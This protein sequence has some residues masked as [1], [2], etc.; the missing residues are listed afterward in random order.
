MC[1]QYSN[2]PMSG[3]RKRGEVVKTVDVLKGLYSLRGRWTDLAASGLSI[4]FLFDKLPLSVGK[5]LERNARLYADSTAIIFENT[6]YTYEELNSMVNRMANFF[7]A[8]GIR[9][10][11]TAIVFLENRPESLMVTAALA[12]LG[13]AASL[14]HP[15]QRGAVLLHS[16][17]LKSSRFF[18]VGE[19]LIDAFEEV[20]PELP[21][22][23][24]LV[25]GLAD[26]GTFDFPD[27]YIDLQRQLSGAGT[28]NPPETGD[29]R[30]GDHL[31]YIFTSGTTGQPK[32]AIQTHK[33][34]LRCM[35]WFGR[36]NLS[37]K[38]DDVLYAP[39]PFFHANVFLIAWPAV[40]TY[41]ATLVMRRKFSVS[42]FWSD[43]RKYNAT[44]FI[45]IGEICRYLLNA[46][47]ALD[48][49]NHR[50]SKVIGN[51]LQPDIWSAFKERFGIA[52]IYE[53]YGASDSNIIFTN[54][55]NMDCSV[56]WSP[57]DFAIIQYDVE[58]DEAVR[59]RKGRCIRVKKGETGLMLS[60]ITKRF[61]FD[62]YVNKASN[63]A[64][65][66]RDVFR[67]GDQW[68]NTGD[69]MKHMGYKHTQFVD[70]IGDTFR[71]KGEN[72]ATAEVEQIIHGLPFV[73]SCAVY[74]IRIPKCDGRAGMAAL[75]SSRPPGAEELEKISALVRA[76]L[77]PYAIP[78][79]LR[80]ADRFDLTETQK[81]RK[82]KLKEEGFDPGTVSDP[83]HVMLPGHK[84]YSLMTRE[85]YEDIVAGKISF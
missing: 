7:K 72:V 82:N 6:S 29:I 59:N 64:K 21:G 18:I 81:I 36:I 69:L 14:V 26:Q 76:E 4:A 57:V 17:R 40:F 55:L 45:Y 56:G 52:H 54:T 16:M 61:P 15:Q 5:I 23:D 48:D 12:K 43:I 10:G 77:P 44:A 20:R 30:A 85:I 41:G 3:G 75:I 70:R 67:R 19:E 62:G 74:G 25:M 68:F 79:F 13:A 46:S 11:D 63:E 27:Y 34:W 65:I 32:A 73:E 2:Y 8:A 83:I 39:L 42:E 71:W 51:G 22:E 60:R 49:R 80:L 1:I 38:Q 28:E 47:P 33:K 35:Q 31:A 53:F 50:V 9:R 37:L 66:F 24:L 84:K 58:S 78:V